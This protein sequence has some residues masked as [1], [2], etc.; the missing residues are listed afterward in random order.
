MDGNS[1]DVRGL[2][3]G[4]ILIGVLGVL[5]DITTAQ[6]AAIEEISL[7]NDKLGFRELYRRGISIGKE[8]IAS[9]VNTLVLAYV[10]ASF[11]VVLLYMLHKNI[12]MWLLLNSNF[13]AEEIIRTVVGSTALV[14][15]VPLTTVMSAYFFS[16]KSNGVM[17]AVKNQEE[18]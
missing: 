1:I 9:L 13:I 12:P 5:D 18:R 2:L 15:A 10:G 11:P 4:G 8:H 3:L 7:A 6:A 16:Q 14:L 17:S